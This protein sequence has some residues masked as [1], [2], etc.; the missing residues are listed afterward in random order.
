MP[1]LE[2]VS[3]SMTAGPPAWVMTAM[4]FPLTSG[5][6]K[7]AHTVVSSWRLEQRTMPAL[8]NKASTMASLVARAPVCDEAAR[9]PAAEPPDLMAAMRQPFMM[10]ERECFN[11]FCG[12]LIFSI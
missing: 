11:S 1:L 4:F 6:M 9:L 3:V 2:R 5:C 12:L 8:R 10:S 7:M